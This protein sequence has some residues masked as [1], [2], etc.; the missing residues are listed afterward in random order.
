MNA[1]Q[2]NTSNLGNQITSNVSNAM[3][4]LPNQQSI[5]EGITSIG[6]TLQ[7]T[8]NQIGESL[9]EFSKQS[10]TVP[11][12]T[13]GFLESNTIIA[14]FAFIILVLVGMLV[15]LNLGVILM[16]ILFGPSENP[17]LIN[18]MVDGNNAMVIRQDPKQDESTTLLRSNNE[19]SG[20]EIYVVFMDLSE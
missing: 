1:P 13:A 6:N 17:F 5:Q 2:G 20:A 19:D 9:N 3:E 11:G 16:S 8:T 14:K 18:G 7:S 10:A 12:A 15:L 4:R